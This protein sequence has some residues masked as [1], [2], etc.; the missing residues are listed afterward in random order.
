MICS[1]TLAC[2][3]ARSTVLASESLPSAG[4][5]TAHTRTPG[6]GSSDDVQGGRLVWSE[7]TGCRDC[8][9]RTVACGA[10]E[11]PSA[12]RAELLARCGAARV[13]LDRAE[14]GPLRVRLLRVLRAHG[15]LSIAAATAEYDRLTG[16]GT[17]GTEGEMRLL[18]DRLAAAGAR[19]HLELPASPE[20]RA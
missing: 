11:L 7:E 16:E 10:G 18:A 17:T 2:R 20:G 1:G 13:R 5:S 19:V 3:L 9:H 8:S 14:A 15:G 4:A 6:C 12:L